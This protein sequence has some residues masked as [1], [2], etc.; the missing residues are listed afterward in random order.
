MFNLAVIIPALNP[1]ETLI[2]YVKSLLSK[3]FREVIVINDG[4][5]E[6][7]SYIFSQLENLDRCTVLTHV[8]NR[9]KGRALKTGFQYYLQHFSDLS[10]V[11]T[12]DADGQHTVEDVCKVAEKLQEVKSHLVLGIR[13]FK[14][15]HVPKRSYIGNTITSFAFYLFFQQKL[16]DT[17]TGLRAIPTREIRRMIQLRGERYEYEINMLIYANKMKLPIEE[18]K[19]KTIYYNNN[20]GSYYKTIRD[21][22]KIF[23]KLVSGV[24]YFRWRYKD[25]FQEIGEKHE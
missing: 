21:S 16:V 11:V 7:L 19:I 3:G 13:D 8:K 10:G 17:Q 24:V 5:R 12:A 4:S 23:R 25:L 6:N 15:A 22:W 14:E 18:V 2:D 20:E 1:E 9:G